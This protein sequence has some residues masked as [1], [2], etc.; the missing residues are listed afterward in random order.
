MLQLMPFLSLF[1]RSDRL[2]VLANTLIQR[3]TARRISTTSLLQ[4]AG[5]VKD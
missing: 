5:R 3:L 1:L 2:S 4:I